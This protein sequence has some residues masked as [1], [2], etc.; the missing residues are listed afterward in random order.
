[1]LQLIRGHVMLVGRNRQPVEACPKEVIGQIP[2]D[3]L[4]QERDMFW[5]ELYFN[6]LVKAGLISKIR[7]RKE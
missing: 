2:D 3:G 6:K 5:G 7:D 1:M 4:N